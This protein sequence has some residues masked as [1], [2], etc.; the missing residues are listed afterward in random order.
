M[1]A[2]ERC[3][4]I[5]C[6]CYSVTVTTLYDDNG[7]IHSRFHRNSRC[8]WLSRSPI[9]VAALQQTYG[10]IRR[11]LGESHAL[12]S[13]AYEEVQRGLGQAALREIECDGLG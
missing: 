7:L 13:P 2:I 8:T 10:R 12:A 6:E 4:K 1:S 5:G 11:V 3:Q 9:F